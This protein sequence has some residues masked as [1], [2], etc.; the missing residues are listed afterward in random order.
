MRPL[1]APDILR[2]WERGVGCHPPERVLLILMAACPEMTRDELAALDVAERDERLLAL[3]GLTLGPHIDG[4][5]E[6]PA[7][8]E[9]LEFA[10][11]AAT[12]RTE[13]GPGPQHE[14]RIEGYAVVFRL[15]NSTDLALAADGEPGAARRLL[16]E[17]CVLEARRDGQSIATSALPAWLETR[18]GER[19]AE[20]APQAERWLDVVCPACGHAWSAAFDIAAFLW[21]E[22]A[23]EAKRLTREVHALARAYAWREADILAMSAMRRQRYLELAGS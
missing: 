5:A 15:P 3:R 7:C 8:Q 14:L 4:V 1:A 6:C 22:I 9:P 20:C 21:A 23:A 10:I 19:M 16:A 12:L 13:R 18:L 11:D 17:R 2:V